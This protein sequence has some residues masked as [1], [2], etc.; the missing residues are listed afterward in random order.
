MKSKKLEE[1]IKDIKRMNLKDKL[2]LGICMCDSNYMS[3]LY[4]KQELLNF[5]DSALREVDEEYRITVINFSRCFNVMFEMSKIMLMTKEQ[6]NKVM[7]Y[8][9]NN[10][11][12]LC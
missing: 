6:Q 10:T 9:Y 12:Q 5:F 8:L 7:L 4:D 11:L 3:E 1:V 2:R